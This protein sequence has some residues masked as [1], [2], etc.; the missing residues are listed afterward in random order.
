MRTRRAPN[1]RALDQGGTIRPKVI[2]TTHTADGVVRLGSDSVKVG[3]SG[4]RRRRPLLLSL[5]TVGLVAGAA[6]LV[7]DARPQIA[8]ATGV[9]LS[10]IVNPVPASWT[11][12]M[13]DGR[14]FAVAQ[15]GDQMVVGGSFSAV[16]RNGQQVSRSGIVAFDATT[17]VINTG[18]HPQLNGDVEALLPG[19]V[20]GT[21]YVG[22]SFTTVD[23]AARPRLVLLRVADGSRVTTFDGA[24][25]P[26]GTVKDIE[27]VGGRLFVAGTFTQVSGISHRGLV[28]L[29]ATTGDVD[30]YVGLS[31]TG[32]HNYDGTGAI[33][34]VGPAELAISPDGSTMV[35]IGNFTD[36]SGASRDQVAMIDLGASASTVRANWNTNRYTPPCDAELYDSYIRDVDFSPDGSYFAIVAVGDRSE[37]T[38]CD[39]L[40]RW[41]TTATGADVQP[42][43]ILDSGGDTLSAV[44]VTTGAIYVG[45][46]QRWLNNPDGADFAGPGA[47]P[48]PGLGA[49]DPV[50]GLPLEWNPG[51]NPRGIG[52][53]AL[54]VT[55]E[56]LWVGSDTDWIGDHQYER[57]KLAF[58]PIEGGE[59]APTGQSPELP[60]SV[61]VAT[62]QLRRSGS[63]GTVFTTPSTVTTSGGMSWSTVTAAVQIDDV[64]YYTRSDRMLYRRTFDGTTFGPQQSIDPYNDPIWSNVNTGSGNLYRGA[65]PDWYDELPSLTGMAYRNGRLYYTLAGSSRLYYRRF[66]PESG[67]VSAERFEAP[68]VTLSG[69][70][71]MFLDGDLLYTVAASTGA[72]SVRSWNG[73]LPGAASSAVSGPAIDGIDWRGRALFVG[74]A[75]PDVPPD[76]PNGPT[77]PT[78]P[79]TPP[80]TPARQIEAAAR[81]DDLAPAVRL[82]AP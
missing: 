35:A 75:G 82:G 53:S 69:T 51:R 81:S 60:G 80:A 2:R 65:R 12:G 28:A 32:H 24:T 44:A 46:H 30:P 67:I 43:W 56:G 17:G 6:A 48:R 16:E 38:L 3:G 5:A 33:G 4:A 19:P 64:L 29:D 31:F 63:N 71:G 27:R 50:A 59:V 49:V 39:T 52:V 23:G 15:V 70:T 11:P 77:L 47:V 73:G 37:G 25:I 76:D 58:F 55:P 78:T 14:V 45:G 54:H 7:P 8:T 36:V 18:F 34:G 22:G 57:P 40:T 62:D 42:T 9:D 21:V 74:P 1:L 20:D 68:G 41:E 61:Y 13:V 79:V 72:L 10:R 26:T 66:S